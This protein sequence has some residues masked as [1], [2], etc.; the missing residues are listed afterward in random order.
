M[1]CQWESVSRAPQRKRMMLTKGALA[2]N[3]TF[4]VLPV[5]DPHRAD[6]VRLRGEVLEVDQHR[7]ASLG[8]DHRTLNA[9]NQKDADNRPNRIRIA[10][11]CL[12]IYIVVA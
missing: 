4:R 11:F 7:V 12:Q 3:I 10:E 1:E 8:H 2:Q 9:C 6:A 5:G